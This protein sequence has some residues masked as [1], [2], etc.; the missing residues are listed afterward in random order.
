MKKRLL[1][2]GFAAALFLTACNG[3]KP[4]ASTTDEVDKA[5]NEMKETMGDSVQLPSEAVA[6]ILAKTWNVPETGDVYSMQ[7][8][9]TGTKNGETF[10]FE[11]GFDEDNNITLSLKLDGGSR[12]EVYAITTDDTGYGLNLSSLDGGRDIYMFPADLQLV[13]PTD[14]RAAGIVGEWSDQSENK[15]VFNKDN[16][17]QIESSDSETDGTYSVV[18]KGDGTLLLNLVVSGGS[19]EY[20]YTLD[21]EG[22][23]LELCSPGTDTVHTWTKQK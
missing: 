11:C 3:Q 7:T 2:I 15:Y 22:K 23:T 1:V 19:L 14:E 20:E 10:T 18:E 5:A 21:G 13:D 17:L 16:G 4:A 12:E 8:D 6:N 9:G